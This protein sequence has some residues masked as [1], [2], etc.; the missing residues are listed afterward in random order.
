MDSREI[1]NRQRISRAEK[2]R[3][4]FQWYK[5]KIIKLDSFSN[6]TVYGFGGVSEYHRM[7]VNYDLFNNILDV[8]DFEYVVKPFGAESGELPAKMVN[9]DILSNKIK[10]ILG[11]EQRRGFDY[12]V[13]AVNA[14]ATTRREQE[15]FGRLRD[16]VV[17]TITAPIKQQLELEAQQQMKGQELTE[18]EKQQIQA[19]IQEK[20]KAMTPDEVK[21]YME[22]EHQD[23]AE[24]M[25]SQLLTYLVQKTGA[26]R[27]FNNGCKHA[28]IAAK[29]IYWVG[30]VNGEP[31]LR[32]C[33]PL[34]FNYDKSPD[35][36]FIEQG[37]WATYE[38]R[39]SPSEVI[40][41]FG[42]ELT[43][44]EIDS[45]YTEF[46]SYIQDPNNYDLFDFS[47]QYNK[48]EKQTVRVFHATWRS[49]REVKFLTYIDEN[50]EEQ[51]T[52]VDESYKMDKKAGDI[53]LTSK[54]IPEVYEGY[55]I[56]A[57]IFKKMRPI[58]G[59][60]RDM[61]NLYYSPLPYK[62]AIYDITNSLPTSLMDRGKVWQYYI[63]IIYY[64]LELMLASDKGKKLMMNINAIPDSAG[65]DIEKFQY[66][67]ESTPFGWFNPNEEGLQYSDIN[68]L[69]KVVDLSMSSD[70]EK[71]VALAEKM[72]SECGFAMGITPQVEGQIAPN[73][74]VGNT[75][76]NLVQNSYVLETFFSLHNIVRA[77]VLTS[78]IE[79]AK[80]C[81]S[82]NKPRKLSYVL[83]DMSLQT[84]NLDPA[85]L[86]NTTLGIFVD[87]GGKAKEI[88]DMISTIAQSAVQNSQAKIA[89][90]ISVL[91][92]D[93][94]SVAEDILRK[95]Q[96]EIQEEAVAAQKAQQESQEKI[97]QMKIANEEKKRQHEKELTILKEE[98]RRKTVIAQ[99]S[100]TGA[101]FNPEQ[102]S[103]N[104][105]VNDF[106]EIAKHG[107]NAE[108]QK[109]KLELEKQ[110]LDAKKKYDTQKL[111]LE[112]RKLSQQ[113]Q[114]STK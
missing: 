19:E 78:L 17:N 26:K 107:L 57:S 81:Y 84:L 36:E 106:L 13:F 70:I 73:E 50:G 55:K 3:N 23:P 41:F 2:E 45:I 52:I 47:R 104:D 99:A 88:K 38:Y 63:N 31:E 42:D 44:S 71:Y 89:D 12:R 9:R 109:S 48:E 66:F 85:L 51:E 82:D 56:G 110:K 62:G 95:S 74:A 35:I 14:D 24:A 75:Q 100:I 10:A 53:S 30:E 32:V 46:A 69:A 11:M 58:P 93:S 76:Q 8:R 60:F 28:A 94:I 103:D 54:W 22:R 65:I 59:Q 87:D 25:C 83:D 33:N 92:Q 49:L 29:E 6:R 43:D 79:V 101:S 113:Q 77:N 15:E 91:K 72:K 98:E 97:E 16:F 1:F 18:E 20:L 4:D 64:R 21:L 34:R 112:K 80:V 68:T 114:K 61:D 40:S 105:G 102:D 39:M 37:E 67:F 111:E 7:K 108:I 96:K 90:I 5:D 27:K 86:D